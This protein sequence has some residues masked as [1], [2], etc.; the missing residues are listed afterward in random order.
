MVLTIYRVWWLTKSKLVLL[1]VGLGGEELSTLEMGMVISAQLW[2]LKRETISCQ[3]RISLYGIAFTA[4][5]DLSRLKSM[6][7]AMVRSLRRFFITSLTQYLLKKSVAAAPVSFRRGPKKQHLN[8]SLFP[9]KHLQSHYQKG[10]KK[11]KKGT[12]KA[13]Q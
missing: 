11:K 4:T 5:E 1:K 12:G 7:G 10:K 13:N 3:G 2:G 8:L 9:T 6:N